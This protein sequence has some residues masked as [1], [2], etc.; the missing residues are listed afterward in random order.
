MIVMPAT[1]ALYIFGAN[2]L[3]NPGQLQMAVHCDAQTI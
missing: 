1:A 2:A 3:L